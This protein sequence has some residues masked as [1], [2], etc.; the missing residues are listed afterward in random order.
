MKFDFILKEEFVKCITDDPADKFAKT[1]VAKAD[2]QHLWRY[3]I[4][5]LYEDIVLGAIITTV[6]KREPKIANLQLLHVFAKHRMRKI[7]SMLVY[8]S[9]QNAFNAGAKYY[10]VSAEPSA[11]KFYEKYGF[12]FWG[13]QKSG[14]ELSMFEMINDHIGKYD[15]DDPVIYKAVHKSGKGGCVEIYANCP[16][17]L[18][19]I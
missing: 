13:K 7:G 4:G 8:M 3:C 14:C 11:V 19:T 16:S 18:C 12:K 15:I 9:M 17:G 10:R 5:A 1:F 6:S 2:Y